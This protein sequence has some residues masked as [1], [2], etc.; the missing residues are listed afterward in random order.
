MKSCSTLS[1]VFLFVC[2]CAC[3]QGPLTR[4]ASTS[5]SQTNSPANT[6][7]G[8][9]A[10]QLQL[11]GQ[12]NETYLIQASTD[13]ENWNVIT[14]SRADA[15]GVVI[16]ADTQAARFKSRFFRGLRSS[17]SAGGP[18][19]VHEAIR[20]QMDPLNPIAEA[21][22]GHSIGGGLTDSQKVALGLNPGVAA[23]PDTHNVIRLLVYTPLR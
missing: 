1:H 12:P 13:L 15:E 3:I 14:I 7:P 19:V 2:A 5:F 17:V 22:V 16:F 23:V 20:L 11:H 4:A 6:A 8:N 21:H 9:G 10:I 18:S